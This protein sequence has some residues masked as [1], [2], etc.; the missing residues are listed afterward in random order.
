[1]RSYYRVPHFVSGNA[2]C[3]EKI[4]C[5]YAA[6]LGCIDTKSSNS[7]PNHERS[8][9]FQ[10]AVPLISEFIATR[11]S[12][13]MSTRTRISGSPTPTK[14]NNNKSSTDS[15][16]VS[17]I[18]ATA[19]IRRLSIRVCADGLAGCSMRWWGG[20]STCCWSGEVDLATLVTR[21]CPCNTGLV[22]LGRKAAFQ[23]GRSRRR[24]LDRLEQVVRDIRGDVLS[25]V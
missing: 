15:S 17:D 10:Q 24:L 14:A 19:C 23:L 8:R 16:N 13:S 6:E 3:V 18:L 7:S 2:R 5:Y 1:M 12:R 4:H 20:E 22:K 25:N 21:S 11:H 9:L